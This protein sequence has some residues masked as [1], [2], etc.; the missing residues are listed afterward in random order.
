[1]STAAQAPTQNG[2][3]SSAASTS[4]SAGAIFRKLHPESYLQRYLAKDY[5]PDG[6]QVGEWRDVSVNTGVSLGC[7]HVS[8]LQHACSS[9]AALLEGVHIPHGSPRTPWPGT[10]VY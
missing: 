8:L 10:D 9:S 3:P 4:A 2:E 5:R 7:H 1:M 6:R